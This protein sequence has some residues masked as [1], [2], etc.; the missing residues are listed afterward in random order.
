METPP[1][2]RG[3]V[4][5]E[6]RTA[7]RGVKL[8]RGVSLIEAQAT[9]GSRDAVWDTYSASLT[10]LGIVDDWSQLPL[11]ELERDCVAHLDAD[12]FRYYIPALMLSVLHDYDPASMRVIGTLSSLYPK[13]DDSWEYHMLRYSLLNHEQ[14]KAIAR[15]LAALPKLA[16]LDSEHQ[17]VV[18][19]A[20]HNYWGEYLQTDSTE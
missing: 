3:A 2:A 20:L 8:G 19:R 10:P 12:G 7:F 16:Q 15:F 6:I 18:P 1:E 4:E 14:K 13:K 11:E 5:S 9:A 17:K